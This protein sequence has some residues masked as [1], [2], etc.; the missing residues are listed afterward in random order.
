MIRNYGSTSK[1]FFFAVCS[2]V[3]HTVTSGGLHPTETQRPQVTKQQLSSEKRPPGCLEYIGDEILPSYIGIKISHEIRIPINQP[4]FNGM[5]FTGFQ[6]C[7][8]GPQ[9]CG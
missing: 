7:S 9:L 2:L 5:S 6:R 4:G 8:V 1:L 3:I